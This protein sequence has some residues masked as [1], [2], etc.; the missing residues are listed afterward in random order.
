MTPSHPV[1]TPSRT[2]SSDPVP[3]PAAYSGT[4]SRTGHDEDSSVH[5][6]PAGKR[7]EMGSSDAVEPLDSR[8]HDQMAPLERTEL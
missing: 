3:R 1:P 2:G 6:V 7:P 8:P 5:P 4:G